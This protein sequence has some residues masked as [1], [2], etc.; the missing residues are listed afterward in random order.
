MA[1]PE[2]TARGPRPTDTAAK[3][4]ADANASCSGTYGHRNH[5]LI[6]GNLSCVFLASGAKLG[7]KSHFRYTSL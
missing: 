3:V 6:D 5:K 1:T 4:L 7:A 2:S